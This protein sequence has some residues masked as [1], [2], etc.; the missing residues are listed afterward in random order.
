MPGSLGTA[1]TGPRTILKQPW[2]E[3]APSA[4][5]RG[6]RTVPGNWVS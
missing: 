4:S 6:T 1:S 2:G 5:D 3:S